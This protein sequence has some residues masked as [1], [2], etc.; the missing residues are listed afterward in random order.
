MVAINK[1]VQWNSNQSSD[2]NEMSLEQIEQRFVVKCIG[3]ILDRMM[4]VVRE[5]NVL[6]ME[7]RR[8]VLRIAMFELLKIVQF[9][10]CHKEGTHEEISQKLRSYDKFANEIISEKFEEICEALHNWRP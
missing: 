8:F 5:A 7:T 4:N 3:I 10:N 9:N 1:N 2:E 6:S